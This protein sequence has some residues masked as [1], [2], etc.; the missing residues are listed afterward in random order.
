MARSWDLKFSSLICSMTVFWI[1]NSL[2][3]SCYFRVKTRVSSF[4]L[5]ETSFWNNPK[6]P[7]FLYPFWFEMV[8]S[9]KERQS[10]K[11]SFKLK[12]LGSRISHNSEHFS[13]NISNLFSSS[14]LL[15][16]NNKLPWRSAQ[17]QRHYNLA[18]ILLID[19]IIEG[20]ANLHYI[21]MWS[22][23]PHL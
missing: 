5:L 12:F 6:S 18:T 10:S 23:P 2:P 19:M 9:I 1:A 3:Q 14:G 8:S 13:L 4:K 15:L 20:F 22:K 11:I 21:V 16:M 7:A 17:S